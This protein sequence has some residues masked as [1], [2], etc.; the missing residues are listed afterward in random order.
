MLKKKFIAVNVALALGALSGSAFATT[1][2]VKD[3][4]DLTA[5]SLISGDIQRVAQPGN[6]AV[7]SD[8]IGTINIVPYYSVQNGNTVVLTITNNDQINGKAVKVRFR[9]AKWSDD[10]LDFQVFL[11]PADVWTAAIYD[12]NGKASITTHDGGDKSCTVPRIT[13]SHDFHDDARLEAG[14]DS[15]TREGY[16]EIITM[17]DIPPLIATPTNNDDTAVSNTRPNA[18]Y[19]IIKHNLTTHEPLCWSTPAAQTALESL[20]EDNYWVTTDNWGASVTTG[21]V[22][23]WGS[24][25]NPGGAPANVTGAVYSSQ[26]QFGPSTAAN[27]YAADDWL[28]FPTRGI[29]TSVTTINVA[30]VKAYTLQATALENRAVVDSVGYSV[31]AANL[32]NGASGGW[33][34]T[35]AVDG[36]KLATVVGSNAIKAYFRQTGEVAAPA[37]YRNITSD[38]IFA[39]EGATDPNLNGGR[40][41]GID[42]LQWDLPDLS[43]PTTQ[44]VADIGWSSASN[45]AAATPVYI[46]GPAGAQRDLVAAALQAEG[47]AVDYVTSN[48]LNAATDIILNQPLRR[49]YY[50]YEAVTSGAAHRVFVDSTGSDKPYRIYGEEN[51]PYQG[52]RGAENDLILTEG[53]LTIGREEEYVPPGSPGIGF[54]PARPQATPASYGLKG[55]VSVW[56]INRANATRSGA[57]DAELTFNNLNTGYQNGWVWVTTIV[58]D[59]DY[60]YYATPQTGNGAGH[61]LL[62]DAPD[63]ELGD[64]DATSGTHSRQLPFVGY[65][66]VNVVSPAMGTN[67]GTTVPLRVGPRL[68]TFTGN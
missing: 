62:K 49:Y 38:K 11:S 58:K 51:T 25:Q 16:V 19:G 14:D 66:A 6:I 5:T 64:D 20:E 32:E 31:G 7:T 1:T 55:E 21:G 57:L 60:S 9:G 42:A 26:G 45:L 56:A 53:N 59:V 27:V 65:A 30:L 22:H 39:A 3:V 10:V 23:L 34:Y 35:D 8:H 4:V 44:P 18:L 43:T 47:F 46:T 61:L 15:G 40:G 48:S 12:N 67:Y 33:V 37:T 36:D 28:Q 54:S 52:L 63:T 29:S 41:A 17:A 50:E 68:G 24:V 13:G 2:Y